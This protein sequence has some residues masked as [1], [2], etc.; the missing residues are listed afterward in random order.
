MPTSF[1]A[2]ENIASDGSG[3]AP[4]RHSPSFLL[5]A[6]QSLFLGLYL[7]LRG[8][9][10]FRTTTALGLG[11]SLELVVW[12]VI[13]N[14]L[15]EGGFS[16]ASLNRKDLIIWAICTASALI[17]IVCG[18]SAWFWPLGMVAMGGCGG[19]SLAL[20]V[21]L[22][23][24]DCLKPTAR[25]ILIS[26]CTSF[27]LVFP[28]LFQKTFGMAAATSMTGSF[29][30]FLGIDLFVNE[31]NGLSLGLRYLFD[32][33]AYHRQWLPGYSPPLST[34][35]FLGLMWAFA[36]LAT[37]FQSLFYRNSPFIRH[38]R[39][40]NVLETRLAE[41]TIHREEMCETPQPPFAVP[42]S[43]NSSHDTIVSRIQRR[44][45]HAARSSSS[46][47]DIGGGFGEKEESIRQPSPLV[48]ANHEPEFEVLRGAPIGMH[49][50][51]MSSPDEPPSRPSSVVSTAFADG[52]RSRPPTFFNESLGPTVTKAIAPPPIPTVVTSPDV[53]VSPTDV[54]FNIPIQQIR[55]S[56]PFVPPTIAE[57]EPAAT[58][59]TSPERRDS[60]SSGGSGGS[61]KGSR[62]S[63]R[64]PVPQ[65]DPELLLNRGLQSGRDV[66]LPPT[67][68]TPSSG[69]DISTILGGNF[70]QQPLPASEMVPF[71]ISTTAPTRD[72][73]SPLHPII[74]PLAAI[75]H[76]PTHVAPAVSHRASSVPTFDG[77]STVSL[78][79]TIEESY[80]TAS[81]REDVSDELG[82]I[83]ILGAERGEGTPDLVR[84][85]TPSEATSNGP[86]V[87]PVDGRGGNLARKEVVGLDLVPSAERLA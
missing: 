71:Q 32:Q 1:A 61:S 40:R 28:P 8:K 26:V 45:R 81:D 80:K 14:T 31:V 51:E 36:V 72:S 74:H 23:G 75:P 65:F 33:N 58:G 62:K 15:G 69:N 82:D 47:S 37:I 5:F 13:V 67:D 34:K 76:S 6:L 22:M 39:Y 25:W 49:P 85:E 54:S 21:M 38:R 3:T 57:P 42:G 44:Y 64:K 63:W 35:V 56:V 4:Y 9:R 20:S 70:G 41:R 7:S 53:P 73:P 16:D 78:G 79:D 24:R 87:T 19:L 50:Q 2:L 11:L 48:K 52:L 17:G 66:S 59:I 18:W 60:A 27:G 29:L 30:F 10:G 86:P 46:G 68:R 83:T 77:P 12:V 55:A 84:N 43:P